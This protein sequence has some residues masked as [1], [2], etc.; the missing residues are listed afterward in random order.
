MTED[1]QMTNASR[2]SVFLRLDRVCDRFAKAW[3]AGQRPRIEDY[4]AE[5]E[6]SERA[7][8][9]RELLKLELEHR[10]GAGEEIWPEQYQ[11][12]F[13]LYHDLVDAV[14]RGSASCGPCSA[15]ADSASGAGNLTATAGE[16]PGLT[17]P[18]VPEGDQGA[19]PVAEALSAGNG[20]ALPRLLGDYELLSQ[21][22]KGGMGVV[23]KARQRSANRIVALKVIRPERLE[24]APP[25][26]R[27]EWLKRFRAEGQAAA[28]VDH[29]HVVTVYEVGEVDGQPFYSMRYVEGRSLADVLRDGPVPDRQAAAYLEPAAR[30]L[31]CAH[32]RDVLHR[33]LKP[34]NILVD[35]GGRPF[36]ADFGL[37][38]WLRDIPDTMQTRGALGTPSY[39]AP[40]QTKDGAQAVPATDV[41]G[42]GATLYALLTGRPPFQDPDPVETLRQVV[43]K[44]PVA[45][46]QLN[47]TIARDL[48]TIC[49]KCLEKEPGKRYPSAQE[50]A[51]ELGR[52]LRQEP[53]KARP[54]SQAERLWRWC[55]RN[56]VVAGLAT[57]VVVAVVTAF[58]LV[59]LSRNH[60]IE[61]AAEKATL[62]DEKSVLA[63]DMTVLAAKERTQ[64]QRV[65]ARLAEHDLDR[66][67][68]LCQQGEAGA[69]MLWLA[70]SLAE[71]PGEDSVLERIIRVNLSGWQAQIHPLEAILP[72]QGPVQA[73]AFSPD[74][75]AVLTGSDDNTGRLWNA[76][77]GKPLGPPLQHQGSVRA[78]AFSPDGKTAL[79][80]SDDNTARLW[81]ARTGK[82]LGAP[83]QHQGFIRAVAFRPDGRAVLTGSL[84]NTARLWDARSGKPLGPPLPYRGAFRAVAFSPDGRAVLTGSRDNTARLWDARTGQPLGPPLQH[85]GMVLGVAFS[86][87][88]RTVLTGLDKTARLWDAQTGKPL[89]QP[90]QHQDAVWAMAFSPDGRAVLTGSHDKTA[91]LSD[92]RTG[93]PLGPPLQ[94]Q[95]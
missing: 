54:V 72:H 7:V 3:L 24:D 14:V 38:K 57:A 25:E 34:G 37:A 86:P 18:Y 17:G 63:A 58:V 70:R 73:V 80:G 42:L 29:D 36:V 43:D 41:Y 20:P 81:D 90:L 28:R 78:V 5:A 44:E 15:A 47:P 16:L 13:P 23:Y 56:P 89:G 69:G 31:H 11:E 88:G 52:F 75:K 6:G 19:D 33:D 12:R 87:D 4:L 27:R 84:D 64:R 32:S 93:Q 9:I 51:E 30:A 45:P 65:Q 22:G 61:L 55:R 85:Q 92:A 59:T 48:E 77:T 82:P 8:L 46:R 35:G 76:R 2:L 74:G 62:A 95:G 39:M 49:L 91:R 83:L 40:E 60:A 79:T 68:A 1:F 53:I 67:L 26:Q 66:G 21:L 10:A 94:H 50:L 71:V